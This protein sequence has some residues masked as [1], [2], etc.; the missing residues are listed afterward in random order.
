LDEICEKNSAAIESIHSFTCKYR[1]DASSSQYWSAY[2]G[3]G[4]YWRL[5]EVFRSRK[6]TKGNPQ[7]LDSYFFPDKVVN[8]AADKRV[9]IGQNT[10][11]PGL[12]HEK[13]ALS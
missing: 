7:Y 1:V 6:K 4:E 12:P 10:L 2:N 8:V 13:R 9:T 3:T 5:G 11:N